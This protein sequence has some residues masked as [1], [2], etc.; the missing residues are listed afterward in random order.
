[1]IPEAEVSGLT[2]MSQ[3]LESLKSEQH[4]CSESPQP[5]CVCVCVCVFKKNNTALPCHTHAS[6]WHGPPSPPFLWEPPGEITMKDPSLRD[7][8]LLWCC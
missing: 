2:L 8:S 5:C 4:D 6:P 7:G 3:S 1:M